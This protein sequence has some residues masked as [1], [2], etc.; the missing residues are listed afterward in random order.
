[1]GIQPD[2][3]SFIRIGR[4]STNPNPIPPAPSLPEIFVWKERRGGRGTDRGGGARKNSHRRRR[5]PIP[6]S[7]LTHQQPH[8]LAAGSSRPGPGIDRIKL[9][10]LQEEDRWAG[11]LYLH[12]LRKKSVYDCTTDT[13]NLGPVWFP[14]YKSGLNFSH[15]RD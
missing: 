6:T 13:F 11:L 10:H 8:S 1:M 4:A 12:F 9:W 15:F 5:H 14:S 7:P 3:K 2:C